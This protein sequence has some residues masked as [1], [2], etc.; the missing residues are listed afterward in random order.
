MAA[1]AVPT[2]AELAQLSKNDL[3]AIVQRSVGKLK[4]QKDRIRKLGHQVKEVSGI[5][6]KTPGVAELAEYGVATASGAMTGLM[7]GKIQRKI[8]DGEEGYTE[9]SLMIGGVDKDLAA[10]LSGAL[11]SF[12]CSRAPYAGVK[13]A[14]AYLKLASIGA[15]S[16]WAGRAAYENA[17][18]PEE[19]EQAA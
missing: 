13:K 11:V 17:L 3:I 12:A 1:L 15:L 19:E 7:M 14:G 6:A 10:A 16:A 9:E 4:A 5:I 8:V 18:A 2:D